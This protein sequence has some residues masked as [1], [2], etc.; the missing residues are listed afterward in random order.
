MEIEPGC[1]RT[2]GGPEFTG[3]KCPPAWQTSRANRQEPCAP[4][5]EEKLR[6]QG[7]KLIAMDGKSINVMAIMATTAPFLIRYFIVIPS[8]CQ[9]E[10]NFGSASVSAGYLPAPFVRE[11]GSGRNH[12]IWG[13]CQWIESRSGRSAKGRNRKIPALCLPCVIEVFSV[14]G[15]G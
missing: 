14:S 13:V 9:P 11:R 1:S 12:R 6:A 2:H 7:E 8:S 5:W 10:Q 4:P 15:G 3:M